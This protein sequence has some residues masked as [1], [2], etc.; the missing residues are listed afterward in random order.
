MKI[1]L[2]ESQYNMLTEAMMPGFRL[3][4]LTSCKS[5]SKKVK[6]CKEML[7]APIGNGSSRMVFQ[8]DDETCLKLAKNEKGVAQNMEEMSIARDGFISYIPIVYNGSDTEN[9]LWIVTQYVLPAKASDFKKVLGIPFSDVS[10]FACHT[11][12]RF[13]Y[14]LGQHMLKYSDRVVSNLYQK[15]EDNDAVIELFNDIHD[16]KANYS[17]FVGDLEGTRNWGLTIEDG[18]ECLVMLDTGFSEEVYNKFYKRI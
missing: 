6:Y 16:L 17:Q 4:Y 3:D 11:D 18:K 12:K 13:N 15:Y 8:I 7:G 2:T 10:L 1:R 14:K 9:G 5:F